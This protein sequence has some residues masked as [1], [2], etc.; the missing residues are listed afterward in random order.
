MVC[1]LRESMNVCFNG[2]NCVKKC[3]SDI[4]CLSMHSLGFLALKMILFAFFYIA[5]YVES[6]YAGYA[7]Y[8][9]S[10]TLPSTS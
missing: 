2:P 7:K 9:D 1:G 4:Q 10:P 3:L 8:V 5:K 6:K